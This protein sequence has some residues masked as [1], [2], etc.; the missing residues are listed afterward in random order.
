M[1]DQKYVDMIFDQVDASK[2][3]GEYV[4]LTK[5]GT[6]M[7]GCC[8]FHKEDTPSFSVN[9]ANDLWYCHGC[10]K[11]GNVINFI[12]EMENMP[13]PMAVKKLLKDELHINLEDTDLQ[14]S[15]EEE[16]KYKRLESMRIIN[17]HLSEFFYKQ[18][19]LDN[20][21]AK[22]ARGY[23]ATRK[24]DDNFCKEMQIGYAPDNGK[25]VVEFCEKKGFDLGLM[26]EM[27][28][29][30]MSEK[31][32]ALYCVY[33][34]RI[35]I[36]IRDRYS[37]IEGFTA[38]TMDEEKDGRK[39]INSS[40]SELYDKS[41]SIFGISMAMREAKRTEKMYLVEG[42]PDVLKLQSVGITN[43]IASLGGAW[44]KEQFQKLRECRMQN[45]T[46]CFIPDS[47]VPKAGEK[48]GAGFKNVLKNGALA[49]QCGFTVTVREIP[50]DLDCD[51]P[52]KVDPD[53]FIDK[54]ERLA[55]LTE[56]EFLIWYVEKKF[57]REAVMEERQKVIEE[58]ADLLILV[59]SE[60]TQES[61]LSELAK[62]T[63]G[64]KGLWRQA[65]NA[66]KRRKQEKLSDKNKKNGIDMLKQ[67]GFR[68]QFNSYYG[69]DKDGDDVRWSNF[70]LKPLF[71]IKDDLRPVRL[72]KIKNDE[73]EDK[74]EIIELDMET[75]TSSKSLRKKLLGIGNYIW[76]AGDEQLISMQ[77]YL[78]K[79]TET[80][81]E[82][83]QL[84]WQREGFYAF[85]NG[86]LNNDGWHPVDELGIVR[87]E[88]GIFYLPA[89]SELY[90][91]SKEL[92]INE[93]KFRYTNY[94][95]ISLHDYFSRICTVFGD[96]A[97]VALAF[98]VGSLFADVIRGHGIKIPIL[99]LFGQ[100]G[101]GKTELAGTLM[102]F[103]LTDANSPNIESSVP[104]L[105][106]HVASVS[107]AMVHI[108]EYK[109]SID[110]K[111]SQ[112]LK[113]LWNGV[114]RMRMNMDKDK[115]REQARVDSVLVLTGQEMP[116]VDFALFT[117]L[118]YLSC[119]KKNFSE[120]DKRNYDDLMKFR[121]MGATHI[122]LEILKHREKVVASIGTAWKKADSD[123]KF[124][125]K[126]E[127]LAVDR[128]RQNW[129]VV[130][131]SYLVLDDAIDWPFSY[132]EL[133][134]LCSDGC[135]K[136]NGLCSTVDEVAGFWQIINVAIQQ[137]QLVKDQDFKLKYVKQLKVTKA[138]EPIEFVGVKPV[139]M[140]RKDIF[141]S[142]YLEMGNRMKVKVLPRESIQKYLENTHEHYGTSSTPER[143]KK[144]SA[145]GFPEVKH[146]FDSTGKVL[147]T[148]TVW[149]KD[150]PICF[151]YDLVSQKYNIMLVSGTS[152]GSDQDEPMQ[153]DTVQQ[154]NLPFA[155][156]DD[157]SD[158]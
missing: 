61:Y 91:N 128:L 58:V 70:C 105:A 90:K 45:V 30:K 51:H 101:T 13:Y 47:D 102:S 17:K 81:V 23:L 8:P 139:L 87:M 115:K 22:A 134:T 71:H 73:P 66:A 32:H 94:S 42:G 56:K 106:D 140:I 135:K 110:E 3:I 155:R 148:K 38:R 4:K 121:M 31:S 93:R 19:Y 24:W 103:F 63:D 12:M 33:R 85:S 122:T 21:E 5:K 156:E 89:F 50:N 133:L 97:K 141:L 95:N 96:N 67:F 53:E 138:R 37:N 100:P 52:K 6:R 15:P 40:N 119:D 84:G 1:I 35:M 142:R 126:D 136:Q 98:Y 132:D 77:R 124:A 36:P 108:D 111:K 137:N 2:V 34:N 104:S 46:L 107:N 80:A 26:Q 14:S 120:E 83:K 109:N 57:D 28:I 18:L 144:F 131:A 130:L 153:H 99:N 116:T 7:W 86:T 152:E 158:D 92:F 27:G 25:D 64:T 147:S 72:F 125:L 78:A 48:L 146:E 49:M 41:R 75:F 62:L 65:L 55:S 123:L 9:L 113:D 76:M 11:G 29:L 16:A 79:V 68:E 10:Q 74:E 82:I 127:Q 151:D 54:P 39:Y 59:K 112:F 145:N 20:P 114:G 149:Y 69:M 44:T 118:I 43:T 157:T 150:R 154:Q 143:F 60:E 129:S 117:R 88:E